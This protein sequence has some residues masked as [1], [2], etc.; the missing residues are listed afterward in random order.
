MSSPAGQDWTPV[1]I[2]RSP[3][4]S[5]ATAA[6]PQGTRTAS[7]TH[8]RYNDDSAA[9]RKVEAADTP[10]KLK[11]LTQESRHLI[12]T[13][14]ATNKWTQIELN[15]RCNFPAN[16]IRD[17]ESGRTCPSPGQLGILNRVLKTGLKYA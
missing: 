2:K 3:G 16:T 12:V 13:L 15:Q 11:Q 17:I 8:V 9:A 10:M 4:H 5:L 14:R 6:A 7:G 1:T